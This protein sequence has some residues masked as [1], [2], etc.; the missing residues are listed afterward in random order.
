MNIF[1]KNKKIFGEKIKMLKDENKITKNNINI[2]KLRINKLLNEEKILLFVLIS[3]PEKL[4]FNIS[5]FS[6]N[7]ELNTLKKDYILTGEF[8]IKL[9]DYISITISMSL[10]FRSH[11]LIF[12]S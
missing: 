8:E 4:E 1:L 6:L 10:S 5:D 3:I 2:I 9:L 11:S 12:K 7:D